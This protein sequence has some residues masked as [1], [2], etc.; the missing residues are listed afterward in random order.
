MQERSAVLVVEDDA[1]VRGL[2][3]AA[4]EAAG[5]ATVAADSL[6]EAASALA[7]DDLDIICIVLDQHLPDGEGVTML[8]TVSDAVGTEV[9]PVI[10]VTGE[11]SAG[12]EIDLLDAG[13]SDFLLKP[14]AIERLIARVAARLRDRAAWLATLETKGLGS[15]APD[16]LHR[17][18]EI[19][20]V[21]EARLYWPVFQPIVDLRDG[22][23]MGVEALTR[24]AD[25]ARPDL[26][27]QTAID[28]GLGKELELATLAAAIE[29]CPEDPDGAFLSLNV[30]PELL[31]RELEAVQSLVEVSPRDVVL[32][33]TERQ[34]IDDYAD[35]Q[36]RIRGMAP[37][38]GL[39][40]DDAGA[41]FA[42]LRHVLMLEPDHMKLDRSW[43]QSIEQSPAKQAMVAGL[44]HFANTTGST[45]IA[46]GVETDAE[47]ETL[48]S[49]GVVVGQGFL[50]GRPERS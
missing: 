46:E 48:L 41:G 38:V 23:A 42:S 8:R 17:A 30:T 50:F 3:C 35:M 21:L 11:D 22:S 47:R 25:G 15:V 26:R 1:S 5:Y 32:E 39:S 29:T 43:V 34:A 6:A 20:I 4:L 16:V 36:A 33:I 2:F 37:P 49:L 40:I 18:E 12:L 44:V 13:A 19:S 45:L 28:V 9:L 27:F 24:F 10:V 14:V 31:A 7:R